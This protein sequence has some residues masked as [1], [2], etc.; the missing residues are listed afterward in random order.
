MTGERVAQAYTG[1][2]VWEVQ[3]LTD[4]VVVCAQRHHP[5]IRRVLVHFRLVQTSLERRSVVVDVGNH[6]L[7]LHLGRLSRCA[8][9]ARD[10]KQLELVGV[11]AIQALGDRQ[12]T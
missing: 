8:L 7:H 2:R 3:I 11:L 6:D 1:W 9:V 5:H 12:Q 10:E 4:V